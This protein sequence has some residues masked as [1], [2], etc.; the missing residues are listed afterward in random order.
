MVPPAAQ[1]VYA[2]GEN[3]AGAVVPVMP[4]GP[5]EAERRRLV[6]GV[7]ALL[8]HEPDLVDYVVL[9]DGVPAG[10]IV[11]DLAGLGPPPV[12]LEN[13]RLG[14]GVPS[15]DGLACG[16]AVAFRHVAEHWPGRHAWKIDTDA[17]VIGP[18]RGR[19][20]AYFAGHPGVGIAGT[21]DRECDGTPRDDA[22]RRL[23]D[24]HRK[25]LWPAWFWKSRR[26]LT[27][28]YT[29]AGRRFADWYR[30]IDRRHARRGRYVQGGSYAV[31]AALLRKWL[32]GGR[33]DRP[34]DWLGAPMPEDIGYSMWAVLDGFAPGDFNGPGEVFG[35]KNIGLPLPPAELVARGYGVVHSVKCPAWADEAAVVAALDAAAAASGITPP[36]RNAPVGLTDAGV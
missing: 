18:C 4:V 21:L 19:I 10:Q 36:G 27:S 5:G 15:Y 23:A 11:D 29:P 7:R 20:A 17:Y 22:F 16:L 35:V 24:V 31:N 6:R 1:P 13:P 33:L 12:L 25:F 14:R 30:G 3:P 28:P 9:H 26:Q 32:D 2:N 8:R 34:L